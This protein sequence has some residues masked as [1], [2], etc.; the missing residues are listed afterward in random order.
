MTIANNLISEALRVSGIVGVGQTPLA[1]DTNTAFTL[2]NQMIGVWNVQRANQANPNT[3]TT[4]ANLTTDVA[5]WTPYEGVLLPNLARTLRMAWTLLPDQ[6]LDQ[7]AGAALQ[8]FQSINAQQIV[9]VHAGVPTTCLQAI[10]LALR[11]AGRINDQQLV[12]DTSKDVDDAMSL[13]ATMVAQWQRRRWLVWDE[14]ETVLTSTGATSYTIGAGGAFNIARPDRISNAFVRLLPGSGTLSVD[15]P[16]SIIEAKED[17]IKIAVKQLQSLPTALWYDSAYPLGVLYFWPVP[18][19]GAYELHVNIKVPLPTLTS[20]S[21]TLSGFPPEHIYA[22]ISNL[23]CRIV[24]LSGGVPSPA[25]AGEARAALNL[26]RMANTQIGTLAMPAP[27]GGRRGGDYS[28]WVGAG[29]G[30]AWTLG[31]SVL[32]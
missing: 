27:L 14:Q 5:F 4:F 28:S 12:T 23:A 11:M 7:S 13:L 22:L 9:P 26:L 10:W 16:L 15:I 18:P 20:T 21:S 19:A 2:L 24:V 17:Y 29:L 31:Q 32:G 25:L 8:L 6:A 1:E 30:Q 3:L